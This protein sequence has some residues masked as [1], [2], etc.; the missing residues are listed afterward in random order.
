MVLPL[1]QYL[2][3]K[4]TV[5]TKSVPITSRNWFQ[6]VEYFWQF[7]WC[8]LRSNIWNIALHNSYWNRLT[9]NISGVY[10]FIADVRFRRGLW[11]GVHRREARS[12]KY[13]PHRKIQG[14]HKD[15]P[16]GQSLRGHHGGLGRHQ[17]LRIH[18]TKRHASVLQEEHVQGQ[19]IGEWKFLSTL[20]TLCISLASHWSPQ[21]VAG[22]LNFVL[23]FILEVL[24][25]CLKIVSFSNSHHVLIIH[26]INF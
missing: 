18:Q 13:R 16:V 4:I 10:C 5:N 8:N 3:K 14:F 20:C 12:E 26:S 23:I 15:S 17:I 21:I 22:Y 1:A 9:E 2:K 7:N 11:N 24:K 19:I 25:L 6:T